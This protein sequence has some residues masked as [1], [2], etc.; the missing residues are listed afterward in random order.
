M[1]GKF[2]DGFKVTKHWLGRGGTWATH[3]E[4]DNRLPIRL[5]KDLGVAKETVFRQWGLAPE[6]FFVQA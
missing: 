1:F 3:K 6:L 2:E 5:F 4:P